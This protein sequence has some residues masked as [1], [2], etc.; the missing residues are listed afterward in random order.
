MYKNKK[1]I[2]FVLSIKHVSVN[3]YAGHDYSPSTSNI[4]KV[5]RVRKGL[6][7]RYCN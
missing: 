1:I 5:T 2:L 3:K 4:S 7:V 6:S